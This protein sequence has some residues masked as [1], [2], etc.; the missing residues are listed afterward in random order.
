VRIT[1]ALIDD[2]DVAAGIDQDLAHRIGDIGGVRA[3]GHGQA[4]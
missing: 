2:D 4:E 1:D 3:G